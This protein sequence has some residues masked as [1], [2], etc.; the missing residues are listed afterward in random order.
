MK[1]DQW[2]EKYLK[3]FEDRGLLQK[4]IDDHGGFAGWVLD[5]VLAVKDIEGENATDHECLWQV[6]VLVDAYLIAVADGVDTE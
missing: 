1:L 2:K 5:G 3:P 6:G 4:T